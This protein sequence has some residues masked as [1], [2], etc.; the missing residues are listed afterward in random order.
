[1]ERSKHTQRARD[2][3][4]LGS[5]HHSRDHRCFSALTILSS[6]CDLDE[7]YARVDMTWALHDNKK[8]MRRCDHRRRRAWESGLIF[9]S[10]K[11]QQTA[12]FYNTCGV[13]P[14]G[15][16]DARINANTPIHSDL[17]ES[18]R[19]RS[20]FKSDVIYDRN[21]AI[22]IPHGPSLWNVH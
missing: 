20:L 7:T 18:M 17:R 14:I 21:S 15:L 4:E 9:L 22:L 2:W 8:P 10:E 16:A 11:W 6:R 19:C 5:T 1:M 12:I 13:L 3:I